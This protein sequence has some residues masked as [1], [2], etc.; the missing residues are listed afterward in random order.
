MVE[1]VLTNLTPRMRKLDLQLLKKSLSHKLWLILE[2]KLK[3]KRRLKWPLEF[4]LR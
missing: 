1:R 4:M 3:K 2:E